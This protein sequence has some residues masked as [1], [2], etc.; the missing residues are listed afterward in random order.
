MRRALNGVD[1]DSAYTHDDDGVA[2][3]AC[4]ALTAEPQPVT[5]PQP[6]RQ[7]Y[8]SGMSCDLTASITSTVVWLAKVDCRHLADAGPVGQCGAGSS[9]GRQ[10]GDPL[11]DAPR[12]H[13]FC[14]PVAHQ[15]HARRRP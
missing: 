5:T 6:T 14:W 3:P 13:R 10:A 4:A 11:V 1:S 9:S 12:S 15:R 2:R 7:S 8:S